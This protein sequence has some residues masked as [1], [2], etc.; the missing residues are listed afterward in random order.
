MAARLSLRLAA[1]GVLVGAFASAACD[2]MCD[3]K[4]RWSQVT[5]TVHLPPEADVAG[6]E[7]AHVCQQATCRSGVLGSFAEFDSPS[8]AF[9]DPLTSSWITKDA[10]G[11]RR[12]QVYS[13]L[14]GPYGTPPAHATETYSLDVVDANGAPTGHLTAAVTYRHVTDDCGTNIWVG[15][16]AD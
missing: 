15:E 5:L 6:P 16:A 7:T 3:D 1:A 13:R 4:G 10:S 14:P 8:V 11:V 12:L 9:A 2:T